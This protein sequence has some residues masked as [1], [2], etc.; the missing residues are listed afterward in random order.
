MRAI[1][2]AALIVALLMMTPAAVRP[3]A[4][5]Q[6]STVSSSDLNR[7]QD[8]V[9]DTSRDISRMRSQDSELASR[10]ESTLDS[11]RDEVT[12]LRVK[13]RKEGSVT[14]S[15]YEDLRGRIEDVR[16][17]ARGTSTPSSSSRGSSSDEAPAAT[18]TP[19]TRTSDTTTRSTRD[20][21]SVIP[22]GQEL[23]VRLQDT[24]SSETNQVEDRFVATTVVDLRV[25]DRVVIPAGS[26]LRGVISSVHKAG[27]LER[28]G[29]LTATFDR[30]TVNGRSYPLRG[31]VIDA[32]ESEGV[33]GEVGKI[34]T[35]AGVGAIIG[36]I[37][38][39]VKGALAGVL[40]G[41]GGVVAATEGKDVVLPAGTLLRVR[42]DSPPAIK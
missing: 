8:L 7:L 28:K 14:R 33:R 1:S 21:D 13:Q 5:W 26:E 9:Y 29:S 27:R 35:G 40:I 31:T 37:L 41:G 18:S 39:G 19:S 4:A 17:Q 20:G 30:L 6:S 24:L 12:Y 2:T 16:S 32:M 36:G 3:L 23:D 38:G 22:V 34:G 11:L 15:E 25:G 10:L 42:L